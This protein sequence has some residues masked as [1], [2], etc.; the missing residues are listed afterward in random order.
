MRRIG[1]IL[2]AVFAPDDFSFIGYIV[3][4]PDF[5]FMFKRRDRFLAYDAFKVVDG[6][7]VAT[8]DRDSWDNPA[9]KRLGVDWDEC[10]IL[11]GMPLVTEGGSKVGVI[12]SVEYDAKSGKTI[13]LQAADG[14]ASRT[15][16][17]SSAIPR[18]LV[19]GYSDGAI[20]VKAAAA[21]IKAEGGLAAKAG[22]QTAI[23]GHAIKTKTESARKTA[24][25]ISK[26][27][28][29]AAGQA[30]DAGSFALGKQLGRTRGMFKA[31]KDEYQKEAGAASLTKKGKGAGGG[32]SAGTAVAKGQI[33]SKSVGK[34]QAL[35]KAEGSAGG[36]KRVK[37]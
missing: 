35:G 20:V 27:A 19:V 1:K 26:N 7:V 2:R 37:K 24:K 34:G 14:I 8:T 9:C 22:E 30:L 28:G 16:I 36:A 11:E 21:S 3:G 6:R 23:V 17:G 31:F 10:L 5:L 33:A 12:D 32:A 18:K 15:I 25:K 29:K 4:R 13:A